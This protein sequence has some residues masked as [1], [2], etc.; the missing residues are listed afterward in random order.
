M[1]EKQG[2]WEQFL[3]NRPEDTVLIFSK[4]SPNGGIAKWTTPTVAADGPDWLDTEGEPIWDNV[5]LSDDG[6]TLS[7]SS[8]PRGGVH[9]YEEYTWSKA[10]DHSGD[11]I[12]L[13]TGG[14]NFDRLSE[15]VD[16][17]RWLETDHYIEEGTDAHNEIM[18]DA[19]EHAKD[20]FK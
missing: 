4:Y 20:M 14:G 10:T 5:S 2:L 6:L 3:E 7:L 11:L 16:F 1:I 18:R 13:Y 19:L 15:L 8:T 9:R 17:G 12:E